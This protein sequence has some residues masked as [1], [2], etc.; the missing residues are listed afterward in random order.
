MNHVITVIRMLPALIEAIKALETAI[1]GRGKGEAKL[2]ALR[3]VLEAADSTIGAL[4]PS[5][6]KVVGVLVATMN[7]TGNL[8]PVGASQPQ[9]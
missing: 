5:L 7:R 4:W 1:P 3:G 8:D 2:A 6:E 9:A